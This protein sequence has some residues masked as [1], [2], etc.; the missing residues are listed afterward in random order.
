MYVLILLCVCAIHLYI[1]GVLQ[2]S[3]MRIY[4]PADVEAVNG[5]DVRLKC[6]F[7]STSAINAD[8]ISVSWSFRPLIPGQEES[9]SVCLWK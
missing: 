3:G 5:T 6:T 1:A 2:V 4:T 9:V 7:Q 8:A